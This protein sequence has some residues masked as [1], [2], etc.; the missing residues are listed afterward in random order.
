MAGDK[1]PE[2]LLH[3]RTFAVSKAC[4]TPPKLK[5]QNRAEKTISKAFSQPGSVVLS[6]DRAVKAYKKGKNSIFV[7]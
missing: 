3:N 6:P 5:Q 2:A 1:V 7:S 4:S